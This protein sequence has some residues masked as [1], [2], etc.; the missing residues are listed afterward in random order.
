MLQKSGY[1]SRVLKDIDKKHSVNEKKN[2]EVLYEM[3]KK[4]NSFVW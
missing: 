3:M 1:Y 2:V 4:V